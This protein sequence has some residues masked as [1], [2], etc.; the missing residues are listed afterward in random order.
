MSELS[1]E[2]K[3]NQ[4]EYTPETIPIKKNTLKF[5]KF[6]DIKVSTKTFIVKTNISLNIDVL[7]ESLPITPYI[8]IPKKRGRKKK[9]VVEDPNKFIKNG[10]II[11][12]EYQNK[13]RGV[14]TKKKTNKPKN[15][16]YFRNSVTIVMMVDSKKINYKISRNGKFQMTGCKY[17]KHAEMCV[18]TF[19]SYIK[20]NK[21][22]YTFDNNDTYLKAIF[23]PA[24]RNIDFA[25]DFIVD[26]EKLDEYFN[27]ST[28]YTSLL[29]TSFGYTGV[30]IKMP[31]QKDIRTLML[32]QI[33]CKNEEWSD[34]NFVKYADYLKM[35]PQKEVEKKINKKRY[36]TFLVFHS[37]KVIMSGME[38]TFMKEPYY[39]FLD[40]IRDCYNFIEERLSE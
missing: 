5:K 6:E 10:S 8:V 1:I 4:P 23:I 20:D 19:W 35:L 24:M 34:D 40:I 36:N 17:D 26:R 7:F 33:V 38:E 29:E 27:R 28:K 30:N 31:L 25:L 13:I 2:N 21:D 32:K 22:I 14:D 3:N 11:T 15:G 9:V 12:L 39:M 37:G 16:A 18:K